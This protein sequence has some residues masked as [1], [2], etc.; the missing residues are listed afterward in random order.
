MP[1]TLTTRAGA[2]DLLPPERTGGRDVQ[3]T[4]TRKN[5]A[6][7]NADVAM[8]GLGTGAP[9][10]TRSKISTS[11]LRN[12]PA[13][14]HLVSDEHDG[15]TRLRSFPRGPRA[16][17]TIRMGDARLKLKEDTD[18][19]YSLLLVDAF[20]SDSIRSTCLPPKRCSCTWIE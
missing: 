8:V 12:R 4:R 15:R 1:F 19:K 6:D 3:R 10:A 14:E 20:S 13:V 16:K 9:H 17:V 11:P 2:T 7:F 5:G 18:R